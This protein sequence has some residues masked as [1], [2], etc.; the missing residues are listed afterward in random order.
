[1]S[2]SQLDFVTKGD[3]PLADRARNV[4]GWQARSLADGIHQYLRDRSNLS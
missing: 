3:E 4:P 1:M 2:V